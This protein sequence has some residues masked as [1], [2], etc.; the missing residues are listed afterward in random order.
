M[1]SKL[2]YTVQ[3]IDEDGAVIDENVF[4]TPKLSLAHEV[5]DQAN[6]QR[7]KWQR[8]KGHYFIV[9]SDVKTESD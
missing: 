2:E 8:L 9:T 7:A 4:V 6:E 1:T 3:K 5:A